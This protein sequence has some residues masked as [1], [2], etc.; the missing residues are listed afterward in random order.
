MPI[1]VAY[2]ISNLG[3]YFN[4]YDAMHGINRVVDEV[5]NEICNRDE[6]EIT[7]VALDGADLL[8]DNIKALLYLENK[9]PPLNCEFNYTFYAGPGVT[10]AYKAVFQATESGTLSLRYL[11]AALYRMAHHRRVTSA[12]P[13][14]DRN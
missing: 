1:K 13:V 4:R 14:F 6:L 3:A 11:R 12:K 9:K 2:D 7:V 10:R 8:N 5:L